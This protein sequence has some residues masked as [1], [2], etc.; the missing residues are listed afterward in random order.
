[1]SRDHKSPV[2]VLPR[3]CSR[4]G[5]TG[6]RSRSSDGWKERFN[7]HHADN[8]LFCRRRPYPSTHANSKWVVGT[9]FAVYSGWFV[10]S[11]LCEHS[12]NMSHNREVKIPRFRFT[13]RVSPFC[14]PIFVDISI[15]TRNFYPFPRGKPWSTRKRQ[16]GT[17]VFC[18]LFVGR[19][20][21]KKLQHLTQINNAHML[22][23]VFNN[24][25]RTSTV[26]VTI[27]SLVFSRRNILDFLSYKSFPDLRVRVRVYHPYP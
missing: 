1:M 3:E 26:K 14:L 24:L 5:S 12:R 9:A 11:R 6:G 25:W 15:F 27:L 10:P 13:V 22:V 4:G 7:I 8:L 2:L 18:L 19:L 17:G 16:T 23:K 21:S 20:N